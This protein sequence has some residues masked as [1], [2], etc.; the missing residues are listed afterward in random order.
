MRSDQKH[1]LSPREKLEPGI[2]IQDGRYRV[3]VTWQGRQVSVGMFETLQEARAARTAEKLAIAAQTFV[4]PA[5]RRQRVKAER[6]AADARAVTVATWAERWLHGDAQD[7]RAASTI[8][9]YESNLTHVLPVIG[10]L[11]LDEVTPDVVAT[12]LAPL[13]EG[14]RANVQRNLHTMFA[15]AIK[16]GVGGIQDNPVPPPPSRRHR[17]AQAVGE[18]HL[19]SPEEIAALARAMPDELALAVHLAG[20]CG[21]RLGEVLGLQRRDLRHLESPTQASVHVERQWNSKLS[22]PAYS[23]TKTQEVRD[24]AIP[25]ALVPVV[26]DH[27]DR[28]VGEEPAAPV[29]PS[30]RDRTRPASQQFF[31]VRWREARDAVRPGFRFHD[32]RHT[33]LTMF[34][35][36]DGTTA[37]IMARGGHADPETAAVYQHT[38]MRRQREL[39]ERLPVVL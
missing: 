8:R 30:L 14:A 33:A 26:R 2:S 35:R 23:P 25:S 1:K 29:F 32:L 21:L 34:A 12:I 18:E 7:T 22:P 28:Y 5:E 17:R 37:D 20:W 9:T 27:V 3:R 24:L 10:A 15:A 6:A 11:R 31:D 36:T 16:A 13:T 4:H 38:S 39:V 19:A